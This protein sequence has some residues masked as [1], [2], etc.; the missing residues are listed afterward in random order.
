M[1][2]TDKPTVSLKSATLWRASLM[3]TLGNTGGTC[4]EKEKSTEDRKLVVETKCKQDQPLTKKAQWEEQPAGNKVTASENAKRTTG[5][6]FQE[7]KQ[8]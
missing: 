5:P 7:W 1:T 4:L 6:K 8:G 2:G 3:E